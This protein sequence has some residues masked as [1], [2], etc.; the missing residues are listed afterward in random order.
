M[1][2]VEQ[3]IAAFPK[4]IQEMLLQLQQTIVQTAPNA[5]ES[6][7]YAMPAYKVNGRPLV[8]FA[9]YKSH[10]GFYATPTGHEAFADELS[11]YRQGKGS[12]QF[13]VDEPLPVNLIKRI[14]IFRI[15]E[16][17]AKTPKGKQKK[18]EH[19]FDRLSAPAQRA[20]AQHNI[21]TPVELSGFTEK[22]ILSLH[23]VGN[24]SI[25]RLT[26]LLTEHGLKFKH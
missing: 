16:N 10:I 24:S 20:L 11:V 3:Y 2:T 1:N 18:V 5:I 13:P 26:A 21:T 22:E 8:Y 7:S 23:G 15:K 12:V 9:G 25:P 4:N 14:V 19:I 6:I 17:E